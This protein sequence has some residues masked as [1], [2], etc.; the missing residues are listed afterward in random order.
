MGGGHYNNILKIGFRDKTFGWKN[1]SFALEFI[2]MSNKDISKINFR[3]KKEGWRFIVEHQ[4][5][6]YIIVEPINKNIFIQGFLKDLYLRPSCY[7]CPSNSFKSGSDITLGDYWGVQNVLPN[8]DDDKGVSLIMINTQKGMSFFNSIDI[9]KEETSYS[10]A[11]KGNP[12]IKTS[13]RIPKER[14]IFF[15]SLT[16]SNLFPLISKLSHRSL[17]KRMCSKIYR[18]IKQKMF[19]G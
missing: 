3:D 4:P 5:E 11:L 13:V 15:G 12:S 9:Q 10:A 18:I 1:F 17:M 6:K 7:A 19:N 16:E 14:K 8:F 2:I